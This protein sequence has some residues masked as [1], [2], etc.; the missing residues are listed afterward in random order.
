MWEEL[1]KERKPGCQ[2]CDTEVGDMYY[3]CPKTGLVS[4][5]KWCKSCYERLCARYISEDV[6]DRCGK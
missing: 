6:R 2:E 5:D 4:K 3:R 1:E